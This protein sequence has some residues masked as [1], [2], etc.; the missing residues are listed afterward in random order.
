MFFRA[1]TFGLIGGFFTFIPGLGVEA[2]DSSYE[3]RYHTYDE[4]TAILR[5][6]A[7]SHPTL[8]KLYSIGKSATG[9]K[10]IWCIEIGNEATGSP[11]TKP[12]AYFDGNQHASEVTGGEATLY[13]AHYLLSRYGHDP[14]VTRLVDTRTVYIVQRGDPDGAEATMT[15]QEG[16][17]ADRPK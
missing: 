6:L 5:D 13:L 9:Q 1:T 7:N 16:A 14:A 2:Q 17:L 15:G 10:E 12:A 8:A 11:E 3:F 4:S